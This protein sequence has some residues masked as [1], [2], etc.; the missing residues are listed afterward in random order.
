[1]KFGVAAGLFIVLSVVLGIGCTDSFSAE[2]VSN[3]HYR[4]S[5]VTPD[6]VKRN[7]T[8]PVAFALLDNVARCDD[9][10]KYEALNSSCLFLPGSTHLL[11]EVENTCMGCRLYP[12]AGQAI[13]L[14]PFLGASLLQ[15]AKF[16]VDSAYWEYR[17]MGSGP[18]A[19]WLLQDDAGRLIQISESLLALMVEAR[20]L[21]PRR[22]PVSAQHRKYCFITEQQPHAVD[23]Q[24]I[25]GHT[26]EVL[27]ALS[28]QDVNVLPYTCRAPFSPYGVHLYSENE[29]ALLTFD[30]LADQHRFHGILR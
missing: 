11:T 13:H 24:S 19:Y 22:K 26:K 3:K 17:M 9:L 23:T 28:L 4:I 2:K 15:V 16:E 18:H 20:P 30:Y 25:L 8:I 12:A 1:M 6:A 7:I 10:A 27:D 29:N 21:K 5:L 14:T